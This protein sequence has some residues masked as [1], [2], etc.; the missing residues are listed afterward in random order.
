MKLQGKNQTGERRRQKKVYAI[1]IASHD[2]KPYANSDCKKART[3][4]LPSTPYC[5]GKYVPARPRGAVNFI[6]VSMRIKSRGWHFLVATTA[7]H[8][9]LFWPSPQ[10]FPPLVMGLPLSLFLL[11]DV[12]CDGIKEEISSYVDVHIRNLILS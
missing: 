2:T 1:E 5:Q 8:Q 10:E 3:R 4:S 6:M 7:H 11:C 9:S 12:S